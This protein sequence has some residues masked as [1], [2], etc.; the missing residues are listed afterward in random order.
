MHVELSED[1]NLNRTEILLSS[2]L[3]WASGYITKIARYLGNLDVKI[4]TSCV[5]K[6]IMQK[7]GYCG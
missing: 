3:H 7:P 2:R 6:P 5:N 4:F 1:N